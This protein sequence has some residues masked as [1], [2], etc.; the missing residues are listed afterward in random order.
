MCNKI[1]GLN[2]QNMQRRAKLYIAQELVH[3]LTEK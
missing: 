2:D 1:K 3:K